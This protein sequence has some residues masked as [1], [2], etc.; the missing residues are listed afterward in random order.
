MPVDDVPLQHARRADEPR[1]ER[2]GGL[3]V[4]L[5]GRAD[6]LDAALVHDD[7]LVRELERLVLVVGDEQ[8]RHAELAVQLV[9]PVPQVL[10]HPG[11]Q[12]AERLVQ[13]Q[14]ARTGRERAGE[15]DALAL[16]AGELVGVAVGE[17][18]ELHELE[19]LVDPGLDVGLGRLA[20]AE[21]EPDVVGDGHVPEQRVVLE[22]EADAAL[23]HASVRVLLVLHPDPPGV[24][25]LEAGEHPQHGAL[26]RAARPEERGDRALLGGE[27]DVVH[28]D[29]AAE[30]LRQ[31]LHDDGG[32]HQSSFISLRF[33]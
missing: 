16:P 6:L 7:D 31:V 22:H 18:R 27:R 4:D 10:A 28:G 19:Q 29:E 30:A 8:R 33:S 14:H 12:R 32:T 3:V 2:R 1:D 11:V 25:R 23:L 20:H 13:Q 9:E 15:R 5:I 24:R 17:R 26:S 21:P